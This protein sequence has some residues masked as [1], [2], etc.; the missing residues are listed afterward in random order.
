MNLK[1]FPSEIISL[2]VDWLD[3]RSKIN[4]GLASRLFVDE[5]KRCIKVE[6]EA[7]VGCKTW[8]VFDKSSSSYVE[9][10]SKTSK[11]CNSQRKWK[12]KKGNLHREDGPALVQKCF[13]FYEETWFL[14]GFRHCVD[15]PAVLMLKNGNPVEVSFFY[16]NQLHNEDGPALTKYDGKGNVIEEKWMIHGKC[17]REDGPAKIEYL[18]TKR[19]E[20]YYLYGV[21]YKLNSFFYLDDGSEK[22]TTIDFRS[23]AFL[24]T[25]HNS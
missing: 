4:F 14:D 12:N 23:K 5:V 16:M 20:R 1:D 25:I 15:G 18:P 3:L 21:E 13:E 2:I 7:D 10:Y 19:L 24:Y 17:H 8:F 6:Y 9:E 11:G 22:L